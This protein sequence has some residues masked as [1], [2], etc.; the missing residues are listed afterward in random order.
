MNTEQWES[1]LLQVKTESQK[2]RSIIS[3]KGI[4]IAGISHTH[5][6]PPRNRKCACCHEKRLCR[7]YKTNLTP[8]RYNTSLCWICSRTILEYQEV[9]EDFLSLNDH[10]YLAYDVKLI[11]ELDPLDIADLSHFESK[12]RKH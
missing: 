4:N 12:R 9:H 1:P 2:R 10:N 6:R 5:E 3:Q 7:L 8:E 11:T